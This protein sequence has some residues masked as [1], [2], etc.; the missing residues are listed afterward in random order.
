MAIQDATFGDL[1]KAQNVVLA[2]ARYTAENATPCKNLIE[3]FRLGQGQK[4]ITVPKIGAAPTLDDLTDGIDIIT[5]KDISLGTT[6][7]TTGEKGGKFILTDKLIRQFNEDVFKMVGRLLGSG[8]DQKVDNDIIALFSALNGGTTLGADNR[9][10]VRENAAGLIAFA[11]ANK[12]PDPVVVVHHANA[13]FILTAST[14]GIYATYYAGVMGGMSEALL[15]NF[16]KFNMDG[17]NFFYDSNIAK[18]TGYDSGYGAV[19]SKSAMCYVESKAWG[20]ERERDASMRA[21]E[22]VITSD[23]GVFELD[24]T[25]GAPAQYEIGAIATT[26]TSTGA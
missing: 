24:D 2:A 12:F 16:W 25:Y 5:S 22:V 21:W 14:Q 3:S 13:L 18:I 26:S 20:T 9:Y 23:Y 7:L 15:R 6:D 4:Q 1:E 8:A 11:R 10:M 19:F 17:I